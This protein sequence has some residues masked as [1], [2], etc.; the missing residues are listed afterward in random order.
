MSAEKLFAVRGAT[1]ADDNS[2]EDILNKT[3]D[4]LRQLIKDNQLRPEAIVSAFFTVTPDLD[5][6]FPAAAARSLGWDNVAMICSTEI[7]VPGAL[8]RGIRVLIQF[9]APAEHKPVNAY[10]GAAERLRPDLFPIPELPEIEKNLLLALVAAEDATQFSSKRCQSTEQLCR[11]VHD[12]LLIQ[13]DMEALT[14]QHLQHLTIERLA[15]YWKNEHGAGW[16]STSLGRQVA[17]ELRRNKA[18]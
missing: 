9:H 15:F 7:P 18:S 8:E 5:T 12:D 13:A 1:Q 16:Y 17:A 14:Y 10:L 11:Q 3:E 4:M 6:A 2:A